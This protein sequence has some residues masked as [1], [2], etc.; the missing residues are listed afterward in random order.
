MAADE[1]SKKRRQVCILPLSVQKQESKKFVPPKTR[2]SCGAAFVQAEARG[3]ASFGRRSSRDEA[4]FIV[5]E[6][7]LNRL[8]SAAGVPLDVMTRAAT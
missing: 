1:K 5:I 2:R 3:A 7:V 8:M 4:V 6:A